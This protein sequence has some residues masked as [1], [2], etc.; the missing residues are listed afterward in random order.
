MYYLYHLSYLSVSA[1]PLPF[2]LWCNIGHN[3]SMGI[4]K[5]STARTVSLHVI[6]LD[7]CLVYIQ[8]FTCRSA[9]TAHLPGHFH[10]N[11]QEFFGELSE[12]GDMSG[13]A[14]HMVSSLSLKYGNA[15]DARDESHQSI[16]N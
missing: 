11:G 4:R 15:K 9:C 14:P 13:L 6:P 8:S 1:A 10:L 16:C 7:I 12:T 2:L 3:S 5:R